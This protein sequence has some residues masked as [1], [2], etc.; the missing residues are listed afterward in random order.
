MEEPQSISQAPE[1]A[2]EDVVYKEHEEKVVEDVVYKEHETPD[3]HG[4]PEQLERARKA[5]K[6]HAMMEDPPTNAELIGW[7]LYGLCTYFIQTVLVPVLFPL[8]ITQV[9]SPTAGVSPSLTQTSRNIQCAKQEML[10]YQRLVDDSIRV[11]ASKFSPARWV[12]VSWSAAILITLPIISHTAHHLD[13]GGG[14]T[15]ARILSFTT[16]IGLLSC[17]LTGFFQ[18]TWL[19]PIYIILIVLASTVGAS[20]HSRN[21]GLMVHGLMSHSNIDIQPFQWRNMKTSWFSSVMTASG[22]IGASAITAFTYHMLRRDD[23]LTSLWV[24]SIFSGLLWAVGISHAFLTNRPGVS[25]QSSSPWLHFLS[26]SKYPHAIGGLASTFLSS[27]STTCIFTSTVLFVVGSLCIRPLIL[28]AMWLVYFTLPTVTLPLLHPVLRSLM[29]A[30][31]V[32][33]QLLGF[34]MSA[35]SSGIGFYFKDD[36]WHEAHILMVALLQGGATGVLHAF[37]QVLVTDCSPRGKEGAFSAWH[38][39]LRTAGAC[40]G[41]AVAVVLPSSVRTSFGLSFLSVILGALV[42]IF[43]KTSHWRGTVA[44]GHVKEI[45]QV[46]R[47]ESASPLN[48]LNTTP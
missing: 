20:I 1:K 12:A 4:V 14:Q 25:L 3:I 39:W 26:I 8:I 40:I 43:G 6:D 23:P 48:G 44:A 37:S 10:L 31:A 36:N 21:L 45:Q 18:N 47:Q 15:H 30:D 2:G 38:A 5:Y 27:F 22:C 29:K 46:T 19:F 9:A 33:M 34:F 42:L 41:F 28:L 7:Y 17:L 16:I 35:V 11:H 32:R 13:S 24:V